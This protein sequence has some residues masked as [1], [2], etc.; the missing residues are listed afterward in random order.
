[1]HSIGEI[2]AEQIIVF[3]VVPVKQIKVIVRN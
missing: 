3:M 1:M 2:K